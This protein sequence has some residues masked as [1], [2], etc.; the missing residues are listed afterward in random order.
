MFISYVLRL[1][2]ERLKDDQFMAEMEAV[3]TGERSIVHSMEEAFDFVLA[4]VAEELAAS[5]QGRQ[6]GR[7]GEET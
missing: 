5:R 6:L 4:T 2:P 3:A 7:V 1:R